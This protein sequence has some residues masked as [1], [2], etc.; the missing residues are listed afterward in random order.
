MDFSNVY[1][2]ARRAEAYSKLEFPGTYYL[3]YRD[4]PGIISDH[5]EGFDAL[6]FGCGTG[7]STRF[8]QRL[9]FNV[10]G[11]DISE[12]ML[13]KA[14]EIDPE[15][16]YHLIVDGDFSQ[17]KR[18]SF[19]LVLSAFTFDN[20]PT[21]KKK[22]EIFKGIRRILKNQGHLINLVSS[23]E[24]YFH[25][26]ASFSTKD[27]PENK[28]AKS[29]DEVRIIQIDTE[30]K[31]PVIDILWTPDYYQATYEKSGLNIIET[32]KPLA[33]TSEPYRWVNETRIAPWTIY[34]LGRTSE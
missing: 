5:I 19:D 7:R 12:E 6:D 9:G 26:W 13:R 31:R 33:K 27:F 22:A 3:A 10:V 11:V 29:G 28:H 8:L 16:N 25:E 21:M 23:P 32:Y 1:E 24:I 15:G 2:D 30:D 20:I 34:V 17:L 4:L 14:R 18:K